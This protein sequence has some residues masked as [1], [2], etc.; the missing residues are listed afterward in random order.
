PGAAAVATS[1]RYRS[2]WRASAATA[3]PPVL[4]P[5][6]VLQHDALH[7]GGL[8]GALGQQLRRARE[9]HRCLGVALRQPSVRALYQRGVERDHVHQVAE[10]ERLLGQ[11]PA[12]GHG[13]KAQRRVEEKLD[14]VVAGLAMDIDG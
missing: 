1:L 12:D 5:K 7:V 11:A 8:Y 13:R 9:Q 14:R 4:V 10:A 6:H 3:P 2:P